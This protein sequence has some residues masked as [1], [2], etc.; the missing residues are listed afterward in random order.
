MS[1]KV[2]NKGASARDGLWRNQS[3]PQDG[4]WGGVRV[5]GCRGRL[6]DLGLFVS[7]SLNIKNRVLESSAYSWQKKSRESCL[8]EASDRKWQLSLSQSFHWR[9]LVSRTASLKYWGCRKCPS[10]PRSPETSPHC[11]RGSMSFGVKAISAIK[12]TPYGN[13]WLHDYLNS[14][15][16]QKRWKITVPKW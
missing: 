2:V 3:C 8:V 14:K 11:E 13:I 7:W 9:E 5:E 15:A 16:G 10:A 1:N 12:L 6:S 4:V